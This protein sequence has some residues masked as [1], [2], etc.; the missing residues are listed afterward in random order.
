MSEN[1]QIRNSTSEFLI[2]TSQ[3]GENSIEVRYE[4]ETIWLSQ[5]MM[6]VLFDVEVSTINYHLKEIFKSDELDEVATV[7]KFQIVQKEGKRQV[8]RE[9]DFINLDGIISVGY[10][11][12]SKRATQFRQWATQIIKEFAV[13]GYVLD[14]KRMENGSF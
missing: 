12:N 8:S 2:F 9:V 14:R 6:S 1:K 7:R 5:K 4:D 3:S 13:K 10:R 11:V